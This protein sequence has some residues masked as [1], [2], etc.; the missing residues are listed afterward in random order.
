MIAKDFISAKTFRAH[1]TNFLRQKKT[2][3]DHRGRRVAGAAG[4]ADV[5]GDTPVHSG[6][7]L[8]AGGEP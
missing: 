1:S 6:Q 7:G 5:A 4:A 3:R 2:L 8:Q